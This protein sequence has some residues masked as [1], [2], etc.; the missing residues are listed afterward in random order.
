[1]GK[2]MGASGEVTDI[3]DEASLQSLRRCPFAIVMFHATWCQ[4]CIDAKPKFK[5]MARG[6]KMQD[7][8]YF[9]CQ[10]DPMPKNE[11]VGRF[12]DNQNL[13]R[14]PTFMCFA[15]GTKRG[16]ALY[17]IQR[18]YKIQGA[19]QTKK[20]NPQAAP[21]H[22]FPT[23]TGPSSRSSRGLRAHALLP[24]RSP[25]PRRPRVSKSGSMLSN[26]SSRRQRR[27]GSAHGFG[28]KR[29]VSFD[30]RRPQVHKY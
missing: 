25:R 29:R 12:I 2:T 4:P 16:E 17:Q 24:S 19:M 8:R 30:G 10:A 9:M 20:P 23:H 7:V 5:I 3:T 18:L 26:H 1:M 28:I 11:E 14:F 21:R 22:S 27:D 13:E 6:N 15:R